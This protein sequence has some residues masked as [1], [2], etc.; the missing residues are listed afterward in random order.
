[1]T[2]AL[3][4]SAG[5]HHG[6][7]VSRRR[8][9]AVAIITRALQ[10]D[11]VD[12]RLHSVWAHLH[13]RRWKHKNISIRTHSRNN[14]PLDTSIEQVYQIPSLPESISYVICKNRSAVQFRYGLL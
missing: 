14:N 8:S 9:V 5:S 10:L 1:M 6:S 4:V 7:V 3:T 13:D 11:G 12:R 2:S